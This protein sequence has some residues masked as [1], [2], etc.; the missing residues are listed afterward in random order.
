[1]AKTILPISN[2]VP[3][4]SLLFRSL[5]EK[6]IEELQ[7]KAAQ[8]WNDHNVH[9]PGITLLEALCYVI[10]EPANQLNFSIEDLIATTQG[11]ADRN[12]NYPSAAT[13]LPCKAV[14]ITD[15]RKIIFDLPEIRNAYFDITNESK[16]A[17]FFDSSLKNLTY[18]AGPDTSPLLWGG[19]Y[20]IQLEMEDDD[21]NANSLATTLVVPFG[22]GTKNVDIIISFKYW[23]E[24]SAPWFAANNIT[25]ITLEDTIVALDNTQYEDYYS[26]WTINFSDGS[27][28]T[29]FPVWVKLVI[30]LAPFDPIIPNLLI[31]LQAA[32]SSI[33]PGSPFVKFKTNL[34]AVQV[35]V[36][37]AHSVF[38]ANRNLGEDLSFFTAMRLQEI[39][40][41]AYVEIL[42]TADPVEIFAE[43]IFAIE[44]F[45]SPRPSFQSLEKLLSKKDFKVEDVFLGPLL[46][47]GFLLEKNLSTLTK[48]NTIYVSDLVHLILDVKDTVTVRDISLSTYFNNF[49]AIIDERNCLKIKKGFKP[50]LSIPRTQLVL[51]R[52]G[53]PVAV[54]QALVNAR[55]AILRANAAAGAG[56][57]AK[58]LDIP[59]GE[60]PGTGYYRSVQYELPVIYGTGSAGIP[61]S[62]P[63]ERLAQLKQ[64]QGYLFLFDQI[65]ANTFSQL[66]N[67]GDLFAVRQ[68]QSKTYYQQTLYNVPGAEDLIGHLSGP[69]TWENF[70]SAPRNDYT[71]LLDEA[72]EPGD[73]FFQRRNTMLDYLLAR[74]AENRQDYAAILS[75]SPG[76]F[77]K[78][79]ILHD[80]EKFLEKYPELSKARAQAYNYKLTSG[81]GI[82]DVWNTE[83][84]GGYVKM[85][86]AKLGFISAM[87]R[88]LFH[89]LS[90]NFDFFD[91]PGARKYK[92][93][94]NGGNELVVS[95]NTFLDDVAAT[96]AIKVFLQIGR[97]REN[98][99]ITQSG[100][101]FSFKLTSGLVDLKYS[102]L[103][104]LAN[105]AAA[106]NVIQSIITIIGEK[107][108][109][110]GIHVVEHI[111]LR[112]R[113]LGATPATSDKLF[114]LLKAEDTTLNDP[115]SHVVTVALPSGKEHDFSVVIPLVVPSVAGYRLRD[116][117]YLLFLQQTILR[118]APAHLLVNIFFL[119]I[120]TD[121]FEALFDD[122]PSLQNFERKLK[123][124]REAVANAAATDAA[125]IDAQRKLVTV[126]EKIYGS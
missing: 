61:L 94:D 37:K 28:V 14:T 103:A 7:K 57:G 62:S 31:A 113:L 40:M 50:K 77:V 120:D 58:D 84:T 66:E 91:P 48:G 69:D 114:E 17:V 19:L 108:S 105:K 47:S 92:L 25:A 64:L 76:N 90:E 45:F 13:N 80:K 55:L 15:F 39:A 112:P 18:D 33:L 16:I 125:K 52:K 111:L 71:K 96:E 4:E 59:F 44:T 49:Q 41:D 106:E 85:V 54:D 122:R 38:N 11:I 23:D 88:T 99:E 60:L 87:E 2:V 29:D 65:L 30:P 43:I 35:I 26:E 126:I 20:S 98:Y 109:L 78:E 42:P 101:I 3:R 117:E 73:T 74:T 102:G 46:D 32:L 21:L 89:P 8:T 68:Q 70:I 34:L 72:G 123:T 118:E 93:K 53:I 27:V 36:N 97:Y 95:Q 22:M 1:M 115:Y 107:Y 51:T 6:G 124:W 9:D 100:G 86:C 82:P 67:V 121:P 24:V 83:N 75:Y 5:R 104:I 81:G 56:P 79:I 110:E 10:T 63:P 116:P 119:D 12:T